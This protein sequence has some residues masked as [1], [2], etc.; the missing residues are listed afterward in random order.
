MTLWMY[1]YVRQYARLHSYTRRVERCELVIV[2]CKK[3]KKKKK[4]KN[5]KLNP[6]IG[7]VNC[8]YIS[9]ARL[10]FVIS[11]QLV[12]IISLDILI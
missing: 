7:Y 3:K 6:I 9:N 4:K 10:V 1:M 8:H 11:L 2:I 5:P 12:Y